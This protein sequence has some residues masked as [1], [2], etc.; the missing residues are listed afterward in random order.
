MSIEWNNVNY[1]KSKIQCNAT[2]KCIQ[3]LWIQLAAAKFHFTVKT[4]RSYWCSNWSW[5]NYKN[6]RKIVSLIETHLH[7]TVEHLMP[8]L[9]SVPS[10]RLPHHFGLNLMVFLWLFLLSLLLSQ[11]PLPH[12]LGLKL[13]V[14]PRLLLLLLLSQLLKL[15]CFFCFVFLFL[16]HCHD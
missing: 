6:I 8:Y 13:I 7:P 5:M 1:D 2:T 9:L 15:F 3:N 14:H 10:G 4:K 12:L 16:F 11:L